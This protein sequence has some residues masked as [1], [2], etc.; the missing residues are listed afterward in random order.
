MVMSDIQ[1]PVALTEAI[2]PIP[3]IRGILVLFWCTMVLPLDL[4]WQ[5]CWIGKPRY[6]RLYRRFGSSNYHGASQTHLL[7]RVCSL[8]EGY[9]NSLFCPKC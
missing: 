8:Y 7:L 1:L 2:L 9:D 5:I 3:P 4:A 6:P